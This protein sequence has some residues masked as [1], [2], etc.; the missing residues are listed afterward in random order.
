MSGHG[1]TSISALPADR[2]LASVMFEF[3]LYQARD[4]ARIAGRRPFAIAGKQLSGNRTGSRGNGG[5]CRTV[6]GRCLVCGCSLVIAGSG[7]RGLLG[8]EVVEEGDHAGPELLGGQG[9]GLRAAAQR[10]PGGAGADGGGG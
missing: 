8:C 2:G 4:R 10:G 5:R 1:A 7:G 3:L 9:V 6:T